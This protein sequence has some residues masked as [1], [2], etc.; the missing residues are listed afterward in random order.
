MKSSVYGR[1]FAGAVVFAILSAATS[2]HGQMTP[3]PV[4]TDADATVARYLDQQSGLSVDQA[5][6]RAVA[7]ADCLDTLLQH[8]AFRGCRVRRARVAHPLYHHER[9]AEA[10]LAPQRRADLAVGA[11]GL[12]RLDDAAVAHAGHRDRRSALGQDHPSRR[13]IGS[14]HATGREA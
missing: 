3:S 11:T 6:A 9:L 7:A 12:C 13:G 5:I 4:V 2:M 8:G 1:R 10:E 14:G